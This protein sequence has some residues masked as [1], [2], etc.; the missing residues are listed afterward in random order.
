MRGRLAQLA[1]ACVFALA[2]CATTAPR[3]TSA[4]HGFLAA[5]V[6]VRGAL[7]RWTSDVADA[8]VVVK[9]AP[10]GRPQDGPG[11]ASGYSKDGYFYFLDLP[12][13][14]YVLVS[15]SFP[16]RGTRYRVTL[17][18]FDLP[19]RAV[20]LKAGKAA[21][22][23]EYQLD[24]RFPEFVEA[25]D[26][27][28]S[29][30]GRL[31][32]FFLKHPPLPRDTDYRN[33]DRTPAAEGKAMLSARVSLAGTGWGPLASLRVRELGT[34]EPVMTDGGLRPKPLPL[35]Q[36]PLF[37]WRDVLEWG[38]PVRTPNGLEWR[39][40]KGGARAAVWHTTT[41]A[42]GFLGWEAAVRELRAGSAVDGPARLEEV[43]VATRTALAGRTTR[44]VYPEAT[45]TGSEQRVMVTETVL[46]PDGYGVYTARL[47]AEKGEFEELLP[48]FR[49]FLTQLVLGPPPPSAPPKQDAV[50][51]YPQ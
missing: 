5:R 27:A 18:D 39:S 40:P 15:A 2:G 45:L 51:F 28:A 41:T 35:K 44:W 1:S 14:R 12:P 36:E 43:K 31:L 13:G 19:K 47:R 24:G 26:R 33:L 50:I 3:P 25:V 8:G 30:V 21:F 46:I 16:A 6:V 22:L 37:A 10:D 42:K 34:P 32:T 49:R 9:L 11:A 4:E 20:E 17:P 48:V 23:G 29:V 7:F 38:E